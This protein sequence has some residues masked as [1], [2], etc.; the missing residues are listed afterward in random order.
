MNLPAI[1]WSEKKRQPFAAGQVTQA[2]A[3]RLFLINGQTITMLNAVRSGKLNTKS[4]S[5]TEN[6]VNI[7][8]GFPLAT[9]GVEDN[10]SLLR[11]GIETHSGG[12]LVTLNTEMLARTV[13]EP[14]YRKLLEKA[15]AFIADGMPLVWASRFSRHAATPIAERTTGVDLVEAL[16]RQPDIPPFAIIGGIDPQVTLKQYPG[17]AAACQYLYDGRVDLSD[18]QA[19]EFATAIRAAKIPLVFLALGVPKQDKLALQLKTR[20]P[21]VWL[22]GVGGTF[23]ILGPQGSRAPQWMQRSGLEWLY[24]F[25]QEPTRL[26]KRYFVHYPAGIYLLLQDHFKSQ[27]KGT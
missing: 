14:E 6:S 1:W 13:R 26:W 3:L 19:D 16:L 2:M 25:L 23:E 8:C 24:R 5:M 12:W 18:T 7:V 27:H 11:Q 22:L 4:A 9:G 21:G 17:A 20:L 10:L 15:D